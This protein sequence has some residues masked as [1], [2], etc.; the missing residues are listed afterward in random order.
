MAVSHIPRECWTQLLLNLLLAKHVHNE[1]LMRCISV[2][3]D[4]SHSKSY[5]DTVTAQRMFCPQ[6]NKLMLDKQDILAISHFSHTFS[7]DEIELNVLKLRIFL[8]KRIEKAMDSNFKSQTSIKVHDVHKHYISQLLLYFD[9]LLAILPIC[10][11]S[12]IYCTVLTHIM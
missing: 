8:F 2:L 1:R 9:Y 10:A 7:W 6:F 11:H 12:V 5:R 4:M 3:W